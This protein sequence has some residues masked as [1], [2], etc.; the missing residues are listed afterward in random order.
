VQV[1]EA[2][3]DEPPRRVEDFATVEP[4]TD[5]GD[6]TVRAAAMSAG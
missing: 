3:G 2:G 6:S 1:D 4:W 5:L